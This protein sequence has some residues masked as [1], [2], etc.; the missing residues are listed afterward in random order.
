LFEAIADP[1]RRTLL[2]RLR[3]GGAQSITDLAADLPMT[4]QAVTKHLDALAAARLVRVRRSGRERLHELDGRPLRDVDD[5]LRPYAEA[6]DRRLDTLKAHL[7][8][9]DG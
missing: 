4:R 3:A 2:D 8:E 9:V 7:E 5:W 6:W 1:T